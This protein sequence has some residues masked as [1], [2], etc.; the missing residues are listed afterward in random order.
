MKI[1]EDTFNKLLKNLKENN[2]NIK[3]KNMLVLKRNLQITLE[4]KQHACEEYNEILQ[5]IATDSRKYMQ[6]LSTQEVQ[7][8]KVK[9]LDTITEHEIFEEE[10][11]QIESPKIYKFDEDEVANEIQTIDRHKSRN[12]ITDLFKLK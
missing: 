2:I 11:G 5:E 1:D 3:E 4:R 8:K 10:K 12:L 6:K 7:N 9:K